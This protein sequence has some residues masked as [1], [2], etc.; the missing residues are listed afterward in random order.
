MQL[1]D[2]GNY[3]EGQPSQVLDINTGAK[4]KGPME[5]GGGYQ[6]RPL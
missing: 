3:Y 5:W 1:K 6:M 4:H 2:K